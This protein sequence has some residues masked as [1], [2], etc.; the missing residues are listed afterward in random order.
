MIKSNK[1]QKTRKMGGLVRKGG[2]F[3]PLRQKSPASISGERND[4]SDE[5]GVSFPSR[6]SDKCF[7]NTVD[8]SFVLV[9]TYGKERLKEVKP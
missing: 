5:G 4:A 3:N 8:R 2:F 7:L 1:R 6:K 9:Y